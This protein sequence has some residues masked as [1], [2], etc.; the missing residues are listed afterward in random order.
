MTRRFLRGNGGRIAVFLLAAALHTFVCAAEDDDGFRGWRGVLEPRAE[1][2]I[3]SEISMRVVSMPKEPGDSCRAG[4]LLVEF[5]ATLPEAAVEAVKARMRAV[6]VNLAGMRSLFDKNQ[7]TAVELAKA[8]S[9]IAQV[10]L[11]L[12]GAEREVRACR[13]YAPFSG[14]IVN[15][16]VREHEWANKGAP[17][18]LLVD[19]AVLRVRFFLPEDSFSAIGVGD[20]VRV[21]VPAA[22]K[23]VPGVV[24]R[25]GVVFD[26]VSRTFDVWADIDNADDLLRAGMTAEVEWPASGGE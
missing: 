20:A 4:D 19:D 18:L 17:L 22:S 11:E 9:E 6:E 21:A 7:V 10:R 5:D 14:K 3:P 1:A 16:K 25:L 15:R 26:P 24:S 12:A 23:T 2:V 13:V 8:E